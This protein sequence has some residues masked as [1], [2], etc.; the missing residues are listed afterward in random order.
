MLTLDRPITLT[1][2]ADALAP[3]DAFGE[4]IKANYGIMT[5]G[6][7]T[8]ELLF[9]LVNP[10]EIPY[11]EGDFINIAMGN[12]RRDTQNIVFGVVN[13][14][15]NRILLEDKSALSYQDIVY[16]DMA[17]RKLGVENVASFMEQV[18]VLRA[19]AGSAHSLTKL[20]EDNLR[21]LR[22]TLTRE[23]APRGGGAKTADAESEAPGK[24]RA[25]YLYGEIYKRLRV[26]EIV[27]SFA[28]FAR[29]A[30]ELHSRVDAREM[31]ISEHLKA[32][33]VF[34][35]NEY[36]REIPAFGYGDAYYNRNLY[37][38]GDV[39]APPGDE[40]SALRRA[41]SAALLQVVD[42]VTTTRAEYPANRRAVWLDVTE[43]LRESARSSV[44]RFLSFREYAA[45]GADARREPADLRSLTLLSQSEES[46]LS[47]HLSEL[48]VLD[49]RRDG[50]AAE[51]EVA[52][53]TARPAQSFAPEEAET[54]ALRERARE[55]LLELA[56]V[57]SARLRSLETPAPRLRERVAEE[58]PPQPLAESRGILAAE[59]AEARTPRAEGAAIS[60]T[61]AERTPGAEAGEAVRAGE[62]DARRAEEAGAAPFAPAPE[63]ETGAPRAPVRAAASEPFSRAKAADAAAREEPEGETL[64]FAG[65]TTLIET[66]AQGD[67]KGYAPA[68]SGKSDADAAARDE[69]I[70]AAL[71]RIMETAP[72]LR[73][74]ERAETLLSE[75]E[76]ETR[77]LASEAAAPRAEGSADAAESAPRA[78]AGGAERDEKVLREM[79][80]RVDRENK[81]RLER[82]RE[83]QT[84]TA[85]AERAAPRP[86]KRRIMRDAL[87]A[88]EDPETVFLEAFA[89][90]DAAPERLSG[91]AGG[92][93]MVFADEASRN[94]VELLRLLEKD[95]AAA[96]AAGVTVAQDPSALIAD[97]AAVEKARAETAA[98][99]AA[100]LGHIAPREDRE[101]LVELRTLASETPHA[102][103]TQAPGPAWER[104][105]IIHKRTPEAPDME[106]FLRERQERRAITERTA[107]DEIRETTVR[108]NEIV[109]HGE[110]MAQNLVAGRADDI[111]EMI[112]KTL[113][114]Q[115]GTITD[116]VYGQLEKK[117]KNEK[118]RR[119]GI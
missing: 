72:A 9:L 115:L 62:T 15:V 51:G 79:L 1:V 23:F 48:R 80:D 3:A 86:D 55:T 60:L 109:T 93:P 113:M 50:R 87:K 38:T 83:L 73:E 27:R 58:A 33:M 114:R 78:E 7:S 21:V 74:T 36:R 66:G 70:A 19:E 32:T 84:N 111:T 11:Q 43:A 45:A 10:P 44:E 40:K 99:P 8:E 47:H 112:N 39:L 37:E 6:F 28:R 2:R 67:G 56:R 76:R 16:L 97:I 94:V 18:R 104:A 91:E 98:P 65:E 95:P 31:R 13:N 102:A 81:E 106:E 53:E 5:A 103:R 92:E 29:S 101:R 34:A 69:A 107:R 52:D 26:P 24:D 75:I 49:D 46:V 119:G 63:A 117:L 57:H 4:R 68:F 105:P 71:S 90:E 59:R 35:L 17:L 116:R 42:N 89:G 108:T 88:I 25:L 41:L 14:I 12:V 82:L 100:A 118:S 61:H 110:Q 85:H 64:V 30:S 22:E 96:A 77:I 20:Y 54:R